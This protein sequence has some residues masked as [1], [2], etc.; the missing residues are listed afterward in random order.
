MCLLI[1]ALGLH[2]WAGWGIQ[3]NHMGIPAHSTHMWGEFMPHGA[4]F[5]QQWMRFNWQM[6]PPFF[7]WAESCV[8]YFVS[9]SQWPSKITQLFNLSSGQLTNALLH[10]LSKLRDFF[11]SIG[12]NVTCYRIKDFVQCLKCQIKQW[13]QK[14]WDNVMGKTLNRFMR[15][16][17]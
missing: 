14:S 6:V 7:P 1:P 4:T 3:S 12:V 8:M 5:D 10:Q 9:S 13:R 17:S 11:F 2:W 16:T 15:T